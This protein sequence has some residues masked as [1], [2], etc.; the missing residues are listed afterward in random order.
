MPLA[1]RASTS[2]ATVRIAESDLGAPLTLANAK[3]AVSRMLAD[4]GQRTL[5]AGRAEFDRDGNVT[6]EVV[7][8][9]GLAVSHVIV[10]AKTGLVADARTHAPLQKKG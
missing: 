6:V 3:Q 5:R 7:T 9:Q 8:L 1:A 4:N 10:D 2:S